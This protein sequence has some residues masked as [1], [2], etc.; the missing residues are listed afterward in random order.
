MLTISIKSIKRWLLPLLLVFLFFIPLIILN[1]QFLKAGGEINKLLDSY[2][3]TAVTWAQAGDLLVSSDSLDDESRGKL[4]EKLQEIQMW[5]LTSELKRL[6][7]LTN[8]DRTVN[9]LIGTLDTLISLAG[10]PGGRIPVTIFAGVGS[11]LESVNHA[12]INFRDKLDVG[13]LILFQ[14]QVLV[15]LL[16]MILVVIAIEDGTRQRLDIESSRRIQIEISKAQEE[17]RNR[18]ALDLH[19]DIAQELS[20]IRMSLSTDESKT[21]KL[22]IVDKLISRI[23][24]LSQ[25]LRTPDFSTELF[26]DAVHDLIVNAE[27]RSRVNIKYLP[28][29]VS[30]HRYQEI[31]GHLYRLIQECLTN[32][33][34]HSGDCR[35]FIEVQE[36]S[37][38]LYYEY[39]DNGA[40]FKPGDDEHS[41]RLGLKG[42]RNR[43]LIMKGQLNISSEPGNGMTLNCRIPLEETGY[44]RF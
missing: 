42:I 15:I 8:F 19:D 17:E 44:V 11:N 5:G 38:A 28:G 36:E 22:E 7:G 40:G 29:K 41:Y 1:R 30:P 33:V 14:A 27:Q 39:R 43:V 6:S 31:Y 25:S 34:K 18:I 23:R 24:D 37:H 32:A 10:E 12:L 35:A 13:I 9:T 2:T 16:L 4:I 26:N 20:W 21:G 3:V